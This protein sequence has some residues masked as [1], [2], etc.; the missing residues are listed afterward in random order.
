MLRSRLIPILLV[1]N[2]GLVKTKKFKNP[3]YV[4]DPLNAVRI[5][6][7]KKCDELVI[8]D[9]DASVK[10]LSPNLSEIKKWAS[11]CRMPLCYGGGIKD[12]STAMEILSYGVEKVSLSSAAIQTPN[13]IEEISKEAGSQSISVVIDVKKSFLGDYKVYIHNGTK[14]EKLGLIDLLKVAQDNGAGEIVINNI[15]LDGT[16][17][18]FDIDLLKKIIEHVSVPLTF[19]GGCGKLEDVSTVLRVINPA[20]IGVGSLF[21]FKGKYNA[22]LINYPDTIQK[23]AILKIDS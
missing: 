21:V 6:N 8:L 12:L 16:M 14:I 11:E 13:L 9:I 2:G 4:G 5:F 22:V 17:S 18:G 20:G 10:K 3:K 7:E 1:Q 23:D 15:S 19:I